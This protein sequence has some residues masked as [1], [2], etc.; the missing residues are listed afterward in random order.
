[1]DHER[2][3]ILWEFHNGVVGGHVGGKATAHKVIQAII[4]WEIL[5]KDAKVYARSCD[6][7]QRVGKSSR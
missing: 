1:M 2:H 5:F 3:D 4:W 6:I 7:C